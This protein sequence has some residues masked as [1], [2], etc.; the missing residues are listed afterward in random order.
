[1]IFH[2]Y[3]AG[4]PCQ[5]LVYSYQESIP[6]RVTGTGYGDAEPPEPETFGFRLLDRKGYP[7]RWL[8]NKLTGGDTSRLLQE[9]LSL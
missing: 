1:M 4:I 8:E 2:T 3:V 9:Y 7:A 5:C 6:M